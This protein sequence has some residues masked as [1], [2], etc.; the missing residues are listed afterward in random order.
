MMKQEQG[1]VFDVKHRVLGDRKEHDRK[2]ANLHSPHT[3]F[4]INHIIHE[5]FSFLS[6]IKNREGFNSIVF[7][8]V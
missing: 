8:C 1:C 2:N 7:D 6:N 5:L 3:T 4:K